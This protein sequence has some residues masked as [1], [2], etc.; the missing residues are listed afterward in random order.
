MSEQA[1]YATRR[2][3]TSPTTTTQGSTTFSPQ[4]PMKL[5]CPWFM[6]G[7]KCGCYLGSCWAFLTQSSTT[8]FP[9]YYTQQ[10]GLAFGEK[11]FAKCSANRDCSWAM[12]CGGDSIHVRFF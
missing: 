1:A 10:L 3:T 5:S 7:T 11:Q 6:D 9:W 2:T 4:C 12:T 8:L